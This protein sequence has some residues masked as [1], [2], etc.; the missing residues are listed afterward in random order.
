MRGRRLRACL[1]G[2]CGLVTAACGASSECG[3]CAEGLVCGAVQPNICA[4]C[5][6]KTCEGEAAECGELDDGCGGTL[7]CGTCAEGACGTGGARANECPCVPQLGRFVA[8]EDDPEDLSRDVLVGDPLVSIEGATTWLY[9]S[10]ALTFTP[11]TP[12]SALARVPLLSPSELDVS[13]LELLSQTAPGSGWVSSPSL[14]NGGLELF[15]G[16]SHPDGDSEDPEL[17]VLH[18]ASVEAPWEGPVRL[19]A[20]G[21][22]GGLDPVFSPLLLP[23][24]RW[25]LYQDAAGPRLARRASATPGDAGFVAEPGAPFADPFDGAHTHV[26][27][28]A[29]KL[30][31]DASAVVYVR[32][33]FF[34]DRPSTSDLRQVELVPGDPPAFRTP[35]PYTRVTIPEGQG[36][37]LGFAEHPDCSTVYF[38]ASSNLLHRAVRCGP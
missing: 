30:A 24:E 20:L 32:E 5:A 7:Q 12:G 15:F 25:L 33:I 38:A 9:F 21:E 34:A 35:E 29:A 8:L 28:H 2:V 17:Y 27:L 6:P 37:V 10:T 3:S 23:G 19:E 1:P 11:Q 13:R 22:P 16:S 26:K 36:L 31:C 14:G 4:P 18:R